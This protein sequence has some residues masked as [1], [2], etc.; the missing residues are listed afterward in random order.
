[1]EFK[2]PIAT[3]AGE[4][5]TVTFDVENQGCQQDS[6]LL[7]L[8]IVGFCA[9]DEALVKLPLVA[10]GDVPTDPMEVRPRPPTNPQPHTPNPKPYTL[11]PTP[12]TINP[13]P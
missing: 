13:T 2:P 12:Y 9:I 3:E 8:K 4:N 5:Y 1:M 10:C 6:P 7:N 11:H